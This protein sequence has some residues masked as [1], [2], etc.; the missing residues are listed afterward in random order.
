L[1]EWVSRGGHTEPFE[2]DREAA[3]DLVRHAVDVAGNAGLVWPDAPM[4]LRPTR[5]LQQVIDEVFLNV[6]TEG[7]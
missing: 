3:G 7:E 6:P 1:L 4:R 5:K 2:L